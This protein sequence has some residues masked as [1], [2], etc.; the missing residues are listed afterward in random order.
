VARQAAALALDPAAL[1]VALGRG[2][3]L[4]S[5]YLPPGAWAAR[6]VPR[7][8]DPG[9]AKKLLA[10]LGTADLGLTLVVPDLGGG[11]EGA[12]LADALRAA[13]AAV[14]FR[15]RVRVEPVEAAAALLRRGEADLGL[16]ETRLEVDDPHFFLRPLLASDAATPGS[17]T[18]VAFL[19]SPLVDGMLG[20]ASQL[21][22][23]P[24]RLRLY[25]RLQAHVAEE[26][27]YQPFYT[28]VQWLV[29]RPEVRDLAL[30]PSG[31]HRLERFW[32]EPPPPPAPPPSAPASGAPAPSAPEAPAP[33][34]TPSPTA[35]P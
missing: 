29:A 30:Q 4:L 5:Q 14:G 10:Q 33:A 21:G 11:L 16:F 19:R 31:L 15:P 27:P 9:R 20:R 28:R 12:R 18:N 6:E 3:R 2:A 35:T 8:F 24:E 22:F 7:P 34:P 32:V 26:G 23:R 13:L 25:Q 17:A 1:Q